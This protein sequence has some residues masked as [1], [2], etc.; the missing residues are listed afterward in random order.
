MIESIHVAGALNVR[1]PDSTAIRLRTP[2]YSGLRTSYA[3]WIRPRMCGPRRRPPESQPVHPAALRRRG[4]VSVYHARRAGR[5]SRQ[6]P[7]PLIRLVSTIKYPSLHRDSRPH[8]IAG[9]LACLSGTGQTAGLAMLGPSLTLRS[10][11]Q[12][13]PWL[14]LRPVRE[15]RSDGHLPLCAVPGAEDQPLPR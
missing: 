5:R 11:T 4:T 1:G 15:A 12:M 10:Q 7:A 8:C 13:R 3:K 14:A 2:P 6:S 9:R